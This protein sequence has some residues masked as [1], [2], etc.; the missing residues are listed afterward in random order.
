MKIVLKGILIDSFSVISISSYVKRPCSINSDLIVVLSIS[1]KI[2]RSVYNRR[3]RNLFEHM[4]VIRLKLASFFNYFAYYLSSL[5]RFL[6][7]IGN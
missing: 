6:L 5:Y 3:K 7:S 4:N 2:E 1:S